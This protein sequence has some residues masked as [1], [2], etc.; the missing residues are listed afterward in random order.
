MINAFPAL[1]VPLDLEEFVDINVDSDIDF[2]EICKS[3]FEFRIIENFLVLFN[4]VDYNQNTK[5]VK[6]SNIFNELFL[7][8]PNNTA[9]KMNS[10]KIM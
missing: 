2:N 10:E 8:L 3:A 5:T 9:L 4:V 7:I 6:K 1:N